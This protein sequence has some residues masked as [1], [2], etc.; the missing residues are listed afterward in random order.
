MN[1][2]EHKESIVV[3]A[4]KIRLCIIMGLLYQNKRCSVFSSE[5]I[6]NKEKHLDQ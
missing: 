1:R 5:F 6:E 2:K 3:I 4:V